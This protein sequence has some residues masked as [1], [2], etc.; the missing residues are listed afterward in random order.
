LFIIIGASAGAVVALCI[1]G[2]IVWRRRSTK[3]VESWAAEPL[4]QYSMNPLFDSETNPQPLWFSDD[5]YT[6]YSAK[7]ATDGSSVFY[8]IEADFQINLHPVYAVPVEST[9][10]SHFETIYA[11]AQQDEQQY[12]L[13]DE[14]TTLASG[15]IYE[16]ASSRIQSTG[17]FSAPD[18]DV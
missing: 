9:D 7:G 6:F 10:G 8:S 16:V 18:V 3:R 2:M 14:R 11:F 17:S 13:Y 5:K 12:V 15:P 4:P 1:V